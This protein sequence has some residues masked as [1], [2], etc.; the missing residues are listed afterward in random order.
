METL[1]L[2]NVPV[3]V[4]FVMLYLF[5]L[6]LPPPPPQAL[7][8]EERSGNGIGASVAERVLRVTER[9]LQEASSSQQVLVRT[10]S[11]EVSH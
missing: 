1:Y 10:R 9:I 6:P 11:R 8:Y 3:F 4:L 5:F 2:F 7:H